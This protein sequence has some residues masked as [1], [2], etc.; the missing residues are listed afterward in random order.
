MPPIVLVLLL[1]ALLGVGVFL[2]LRFRS[3]GPSVEQRLNDYG[4]G[5]DGLSGDPTTAVVK[6]SNTREIVT[7]RLDKALKGRSFAQE[8]SRNL[9]KADIKLTVGEFVGVKIISMGICFAVGVFL[10]RGFGSFSIIVGILVGL[11]GLYLPDIYIKRKGNKRVKT[12]NNQLGDTIMMMANALRSGSS[13][14]QTMELISHEAPVP[15]SDE[16]N[17]IIREISLGIST[18]E[19]LGNTLRRVPSDDLEL[20]IT[21]INIQAEVG[22][23]LAVILDKIGFTIRERIRIKGEIKVL[24]AQGQYAGYIIS[25]LPLALTG[26]L[27]LIA[28]NYV[29]KMFP[30]PY[31]CMPICGIILILSGFF[32]IMKIVDIDV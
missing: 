21:A 18:R 8:I 9:A 28:P 29:T 20:L 32:A 2:F 30:W 16:F 10:G 7:E 22:G 17:R 14:L 4:G 24:T 15:M 27:M 13:L 31:T 19:A 1:V 12:F 11:A 23:N 5:S 6:A 26:V 25:G 3:Q